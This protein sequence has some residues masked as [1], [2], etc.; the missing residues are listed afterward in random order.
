MSTE[1]RL[2]DLER[3][4][5]LLET[6]RA[7]SDVQRDGYVNHTPLR[8]ARLALGWTIRDLADAI[9]CHCSAVASWE[10]GATKL[11]RARAERI[12]EVFV[13]EGQDPPAFV[14][15]VTATEDQ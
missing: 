1:D 6:K 10:T 9:P 4:V 13:A 12:C 5:A 15:P 14:F 2:K 8:P 11:S 3:R 7:R